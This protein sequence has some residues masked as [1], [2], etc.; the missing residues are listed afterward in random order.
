[1]VRRSGS[2]PGTFTARLE[3]VS[4][5]AVLGLVAAVLVAFCFVQ[6]QQHLLRHRAKR[7]LADFQSIRLHQT[8]WADA[9]TLMMRWGEW[10]HYD[11]ECTAADC[12]YTITLADIVTRAAEGDPHSDRFWWWYR[13]VVNSYELLGGKG[14]I[15]RVRFLVQD[16]TIWRSSVAL[17]LE[18]P[19]RTLSGDDG[20]YWIGVL[21][22]SSD[23]LRQRYVRQRVVGPW[24][25]GDNDQLA[26]HPD[27]KAGRPGGCETCL[28]AEVTFTPQI[29]PEE[30]KR[31][32]DYNLSC[33][34]RFHD[35][36]NLPDV[37]P[38]ARDWHFYPT[39]E[40]AYREPP[41]GPPHPCEVPLLVVA[42][43][44]QRILL[45]DALSAETKKEQFGS[46]AWE[47]ENA[48]VRLVRV[49]K[50]TMPVTANV[51]FA[52]QPASEQVQES[53]AAESLRPGKRYIVVPEEEA[54]LPVVTL[55]FCGVFEDSPQAEEQMERGF[56]LNDK[57]RHRD[58]YGGNW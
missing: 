42:R 20:G 39:T 11:G 28:S 13:W 4:R 22:K 10:G 25:L 35:C 8:P 43:D 17:R 33:I 24:V 40:P 19:P 45:V 26:Q 5:T 51:V 23:A 58:D 56:A 41:L 12:D 15:M 31:V 21:A 3:A 36:L 46:D 6:V 9:Q 57:L 7:L 55:G 53:H 32:S 48:K 50:G 47:V 18:V 29:S 27:Y 16:G 38:I 49:L 44:A 34:T 52:V 37:L 14:A 2:G 30:L 1:M 54:S